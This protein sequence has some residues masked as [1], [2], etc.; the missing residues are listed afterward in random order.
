MQTIYELTNCINFRYL[1]LKKRINV[2][3]G[4]KFVNGLVVNEA[5]V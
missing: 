5:N 4:E 3:G 1:N 2:N